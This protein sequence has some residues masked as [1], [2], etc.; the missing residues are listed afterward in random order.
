MYNT[1]V[2]CT[3]DYFPL[4][5]KD[6]SVQFP[7]FEW[8]VSNEKRYLCKN[9]YKAIFSMMILANDERIQEY[10]NGNLGIGY[11]CDEVCFHEGGNGT[12]LGCPINRIITKSLYST[13][14]TIRI[15][16]PLPRT[17]VTR[18]IVLFIFN[19]ILLRV[20]KE[21]IIN[22]WDTYFLPKFITNKTKNFEPW[23][24]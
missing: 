5:T 10:I 20:R 19:D 15:N 2:L 24:Q 17:I 11:V 21:E 13:A 14:S 16:F 22:L 7:L 12:G 23:Y 8:A 18:D 9:M 6:F 1:G 4:P 3:R